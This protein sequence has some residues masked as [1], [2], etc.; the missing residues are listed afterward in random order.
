LALIFIPQTFFMKNSFKSSKGQSGAGGPVSN[1]GFAKF[2]ATLPERLAFSDA[3]GTIAITA[4]VANSDTRQKRSSTSLNFYGDNANEPV[5]VPRKFG[6]IVL[7]ATGISSAVLPDIR[8]AVRRNPSEQDHVGGNDPKLVS[9]NGVARA[10]LKTSD[11]N[12]DPTQGSF[13]VA[14][15]TGSGS[16]DWDHPSNIIAVMNFI[17]IKVSLINNDSGA[18]YIE[19][20]FQDEPVYADNKVYFGGA[21]YPGHIAMYEGSSTGSVAPQNGFKILIEGGGANARNG[22]D[23]IFAGFIGN[24]TNWYLDD[25]TTPPTAVSRK[26]FYNSGKTLYGGNN[27]ASGSFPM[28]D[29][30]VPEFFDPQTWINKGGY[31]IMRGTSDINFTRISPDPTYGWAFMVSASDFPGM[32]GPAVKVYGGT[33]YPAIA[34][35]GGISFTD[36]LA[37]Y[38]LMFPKNYSVLGRVSWRI[39][40]K[41][42]KT[43]SGSQP[44]AAI[45]ARAYGPV[46]IDVVGCPQSDT[47]AGV[48]TVWPTFS[49]CLE[50]VWHYP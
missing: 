48:K 45:D 49:S 39:S 9:I 44:W 31:N 32:E 16:L 25:S 41:Y 42:V 15:Y 34:S 30:K 18:V 27:L 35:E 19:T 36:F 26:I 33:N 46:L 5:V 14:I 29:K 10:T 47:V 37:C 28:L 8:W 22:V 43:E 2:F 50:W 1:R 23:Q 7:V 24:A 11:V 40:L 20:N 3:S 13:N 12:G 6:D 21:A 17:L 38:S 4:S